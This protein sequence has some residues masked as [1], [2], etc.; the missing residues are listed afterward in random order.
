MMVDQ[1][2]FL[3]AC[4]CQQ[5]IVFRRVTVEFI[6]FKWTHERNNCT[7]SLSFILLQHLYVFEIP[8][9]LFE[10]DEHVCFE[11]VDMF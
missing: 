7:R 10:M 11:W 4:Q 6:S 3:W 9:L 2:I 8:C 5:I 1:V